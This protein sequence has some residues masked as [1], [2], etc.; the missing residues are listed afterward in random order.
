MSHLLWYPGHDLSLPNIV[1]AENCHLYDSDGKVYVDLESG[2]WST[3]IGHAHPRIVQALSDQAAR[4]AHT[5]FCY[6]STV[7]EEAAQ[8]ILSLTNTDDINEMYPKW[9]PV[10]D[11]IVYNTTDGIIYKLKLKID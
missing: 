8:E 10:D 7:V 6:S 3:A 5:G 9:S 4:I 2:V 1:R 11:E